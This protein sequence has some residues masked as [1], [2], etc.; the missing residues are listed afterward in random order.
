MQVPVNEDA[1]VSFPGGG[2]VSQRVAGATAGELY[3]FNDNGAFLWSY[4][5]SAGVWAMDAL[6]DTIGGKWYIIAADVGGKV[7]S[8]DAAT[9]TEVWQTQFLSAFAEDLA[10]IP[11]IDED[12]FPDV[13]VQ[14]LTPT[15]Q[16]YS[17]KTGAVIRSFTTG[18]NNLDAGLLGDLNRPMAF[19]EVGIA[20]LDNKIWVFSGKNPD[21]LFTYTFGPGLNAK[22]S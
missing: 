7:Y 17:G 4:P 21:V 22:G 2:V 11:D 9:G 5:T 13:M 15:M 3:A 16:I 12:G 8:V 10:I 18:H 1:V 20:S 6:Y 14:T 19:P